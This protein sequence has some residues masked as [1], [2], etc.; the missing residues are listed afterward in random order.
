MGANGVEHLPRRLS[1]LDA[2]VL[3]LERDL[4]IVVARRLWHLWAEFLFVLPGAN[5]LARLIR[6]PPLSWPAL[7]NFGSSRAACLARHVHVS[8][9]RRSLSV[10]LVQLQS[11][12]CEASTC[13]KFAVA[14]SPIP[15]TCLA[16]Q[17]SLANFSSHFKRQIATHRCRANLRSSPQDL[18]WTRLLCSTLKKFARQT[19]IQSQSEKL[20]EMLPLATVLLVSR[21]HRPRPSSGSSGPQIVPAACNRRPVPVFSPS[22]SSVRP[23]V[24]PPS[25]HHRQR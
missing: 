12:S 18:S 24:R 13:N 4:H 9:P 2:Q 6:A 10:R 7:A 22:P 21:R 5:C 8:S 15:S 16:P 20:R 11:R 14:C 3:H 17:N 1:E 25:N 23:L 19:Q